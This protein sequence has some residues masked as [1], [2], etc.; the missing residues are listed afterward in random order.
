VNGTTI[1]VFLFGATFLASFA[2]GLAGFAYALIAAGVFLQFLP[3]P[4]AAALIIAGSIAAQT[5][6]VFRLGSAM[7]WPRLW[8]FLLGGV[9]GVPAGVMILAKVDA[10][11]FRFCIGVFLVAY[12]AFMLARRTPLTI[13]GGGRFADGTA[14]M[15]GGVMAGMAGL[16]GAIPTIWCTMRGVFQPFI[17][18][19]Q[20]VAL[21]AL[22]GAGV[23][24]ASTGIA[25]LICLPAVIV[26][27]WLGHKLY[28]RVDDQQF[29]RIVLLLLLM[30][31]VAL[32]V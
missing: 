25:F 3:P 26:G 27:T 17:L 6:T 7:N 13:A 2:S 24:T 5:M 16:S 11:L 12:S 23:V 20:C 1:Y 10:G 30:S 31:G 9:V 14:G 4:E 21:I 32:V 8:P 28:R 22:G 29:R 18:V 15:I 19:I